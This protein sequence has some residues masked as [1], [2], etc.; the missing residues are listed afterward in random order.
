M[1]IWLSTWVD[2]LRAKDAC[3]AGFPPE[4]SSSQ[5]A[6]LEG[7][8]A[9]TDR[10]G[11]KVRSA[12]MSACSVMSQ[13]SP[14]RNTLGAQPPAGSAARAGS[15]PLQRR[16]SPQ[17]DTTPP[18]HRGNLLQ[19]K[20]RNSLRTSVRSVYQLIKHLKKKMVIDD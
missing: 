9:R 12:C 17:P 5:D 16:D 7:W 6:R 18:G 4:P 2:S 11:A 20:N 8:S 15:A 3:S 13:G 10:M 1:V 19:V 14:P